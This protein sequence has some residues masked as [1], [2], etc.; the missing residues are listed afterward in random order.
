MFLDSHGASVDDADVFVVDEFPPP[1]QDKKWAVMAADRG[2]QLVHGV[3][4]GLYFLRRSL[5]PF[6]SEY[7]VF[8]E[9]IHVVLGIKDPQLLGRGLE[10]GIA[11]VL[12]AVNISRTILGK[13]LTT[14]LFIYNRLG[15][16]YDM[17]WEQY[18]DA[19]RTAGLLYERYGLEGLYSILGGGRKRVKDIEFKL[20]SGKSQ[21]LDLPS[22]DILSEDIE[23]VD[24]V[25]HVYPR[26][27]VVS[28][29]ARHIARYAQAG[30]T[31]R[32]VMTMA[33]VTLDDGLA[34]LDELA[35][36]TT[37]LGLRK[38]RSVIPW[39]D[40]VMYSMANAIRYRL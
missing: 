30:L 3:A 20:L 12:G 22:G 4:P 14:N 29:L 5:R 35:Q 26:A 40:S 17:F 15:D 10:E 23:L 28:P 21:E 27:T 2:D 8:H 34:A 1:Y 33:N 7:L 9:I 16:D 38:D 11:E 25:F 18:L 31:V 13:E 6:Y 36:D 32:E 19:T 24:S 39:S 37:S